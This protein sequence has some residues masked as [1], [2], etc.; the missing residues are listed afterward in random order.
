[1]GEG[2]QGSLGSCS[3]KPGRT[4]DEPLDGPCGH[5]KPLRTEAIT[6]E[7]EARS[8]RPMKVLS[9]CF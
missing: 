6:H 2:P 7:V 8:I 1:M 5:G 9:G 3:V 4:R